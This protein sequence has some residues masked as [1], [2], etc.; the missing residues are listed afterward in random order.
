MIAVFRLPSVPHN[1]RGYIS[2]PINSGL[3]R[4][5]YLTGNTRT[6]LLE[7]RNTRCR[8]IIIELT[9]LRGKGC[10]ETILKLRGWISRR[11]HLDE[12]VI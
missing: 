10:V 12:V 2:T 11:V 5:V 1:P 8:M 3:R 6:K 4:S 9:E 7:A